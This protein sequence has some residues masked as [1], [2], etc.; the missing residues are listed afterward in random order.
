[1]GVGRGLAINQAEVATLQN[2]FGIKRYFRSQ[3][4][5][6]ATHIAQQHAARRRWECPVLSSDARCSAP[7]DQ[8]SGQ[9]SAFRLLT[10]YSPLPSGPSGACDACHLHPH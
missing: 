2:H 10:D 1:M 3:S 9:N 8:V 5:E 7:K 4:G 6:A